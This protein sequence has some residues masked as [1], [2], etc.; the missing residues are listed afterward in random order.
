MLRFVGKVLLGLVLLV[1][2]TAAALAGYRAWRQHETEQALA[3]ATP[4][5]IDEGLFVPVRGGEQWITIR[6]TDGSNP[7]LLIVH[8][9]PGTPLSPLA[10]AFLPYER[11]WTVVQWDQPGAG[12]TFGRAGDT[13]PA[14]TTLADIAADGIAVTELVRQRLGKDQVVLLGLSWGSAVGLEMARARPELYTAYVG[15]GLFVHRDDGR[16]VAY[17]RVLERARSQNNAAAVAELEEIGP[18]PYADPVRTR[19]LNRRIDAFSTAAETS[20]ASRLGE[21]LL[22]PRQSLGDVASYAGGYVAS[23]E[24]FDLGAMDLRKSGRSFAL[25]IFIFQGG[26]DFETPV[27]LARD[28]LDSVSAPRKELVTLPNGGHTALV[29]DRASFL[30]ELNARVLPLAAPVER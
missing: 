23:D 30:A 20:P 22:A 9:G 4:N 28:W 29:Y 15:T 3:I 10:A 8:G 19:A 6:G 18:P 1:L 16:A 14:T 27:E 24:Q 25:P 21:L 11:E 7:V 26:E 2:T 13:L 17:R 12:R 5:G